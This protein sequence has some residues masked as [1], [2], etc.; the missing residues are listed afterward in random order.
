MF[1]EGVWPIALP[2]PVVVGRWGV[3]KAIGAEAMW[4]AK[5]VCRLP[6]PYR[7]WW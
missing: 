5:G 3:G 6:C 7:M 2:L 1:G 4:L